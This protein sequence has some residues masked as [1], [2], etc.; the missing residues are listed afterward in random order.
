MK[1][2]KWTGKDIEGI[3]MAFL[4]TEIDASGRVCREVGVDANEEIV[5]RFPSKEFP[6]GEYGLFDVQTIEVAGLASNISHEAFES[7]WGKSR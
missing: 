7:L 2:V 5:H 6:S 1:Y 4:A 3:E